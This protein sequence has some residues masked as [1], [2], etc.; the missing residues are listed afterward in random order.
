MISR[1]SLDLSS[2]WLNAAGSLGYT[3]PS[4]WPLELPWGGFVTQAISRRPRIPAESRGL[5][6]FPGGALLHT[7]WPNP[8]VRAVIKAHGRRW[9]RS[10]LPVWAHLLA[11]EP[12]EIHEMSRMLEGL[13]GLAALEIGLPPGAAPEL[14]AGMIAAAGQELPA[15]AAV[16]LNDCCPP[17]VDALAKAGAAALVIGP[18]RGGL[19]DEKGGLLTGRL[20]GPALLPLVFQA[21]RAYRDCG[22]PL[23]AGCGV[24]SQ[25]DGEAL[26][27][28]GAWAVQVDTWLWG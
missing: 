15:V 16:P 24:Y 23:I 26:L 28:A 9:A 27:A 4:R 13:E 7:G 6:N 11:A 3:L 17:L 5:L 21:L 22:L 20:Y 10:A 2:P 18:P 1:Q 19:P 25:A 12:H 14:A 8:G